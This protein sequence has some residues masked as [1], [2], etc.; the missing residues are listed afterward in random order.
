MLFLPFSTDAPLYHKPWGT[1]GIIVLTAL[2]T[3]LSWA[4]LLEDEAW[5]LVLHEGLHPHQW[6]T[7]NFMHIGIFHLVLNLI[8]LWPLGLLVEGKVGTA[9]FLAV[10]FAI[11]ALQCGVE[12]FLQ[13][14]PLED[15][16]SMDWLWDVEVTG[17][18]SSILFGLVAMALLWA[19]RNRVSIFW[20]ILYRFGT[21]SITI[22]W[23]AIW[24]L[25][26]ELAWGTLGFLIWGASDDLL[27]LSSILHLMGA[28]PGAFIG[29]LMLKREWVDCEGWD[30]LSIRAGKHR[31]NLTVEGRFEVVKPP[32]RDRSLA[33]KETA[34]ERLA[35]L[36]SDQR[37]SLR[38]F[39]DYLNA[40]DLDL[41]KEVYDAMHTTARAEEIAPPLIEAAA[42]RK[43]IQLLMTAKRWAEVQP[44]AVR[45]MKSHPSEAGPIGLALAEHVIARSQ[46]SKA[47]KIL[48]AVEGSLDLAGMEKRDELVARARELI[49]AGT[50]EFD[51]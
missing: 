15:S 23:M 34:D 4:G 6:L 37:T 8:M 10:F 48:S 13:R 19:P 33:V 30:L 46:P 35:R 45:F 17:G 5:Y 42:E 11:G 31:E 29:W 2:L 41:A 3:T 36:V 16:D 44:L 43:L 47:L 32:S 22:F 39:T 49:D 27:D 21:F 26:V 25:L 9:R 20:W 40:D 50:L 38:L 24:F 28:I 7:S 14:N 51:E 18:N 12:Q 1:A